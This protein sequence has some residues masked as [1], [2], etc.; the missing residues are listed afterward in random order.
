MLRKTFILTAVLF[1]FFVIITATLSNVVA[2]NTH[3]VRSDEVYSEA[4]ALKYRRESIRSSDGKGWKRDIQGVFEN[5]QLETLAV[6]E[7]IARYKKMLKSDKGFR[8]SSGKLVS[9]RDLNCNDLSDKTFDFH[10]LRCLEVM[11]SDDDLHIAEVRNSSF[12]AADLEGAIFRNVYF[13]SCCFKEANLRNVYAL[14]PAAPDSGVMFNDCD[15][16]G[17][18]IGGAKF[19]SITRKQL[20]STSNFR[21]YKGREYTYGDRKRVNLANCIFM[22]LNAHIVDN[23]QPTEE[24][25]LSGVDFNK[26]NNGNPTPAPLHAIGVKFG[27]FE[28][29]NCNFQ[30]ANLRKSRFYKCNLEG[31]NFTKANLADANFGQCILSKCSFKDAEVKNVRFIDYCLLSSYDGFTAASIDDFIQHPMD[32]I[33]SKSLLYNMYFNPYYS[34]SFSTVDA[35]VEYKR[36]PIPAEK[37]ITA[38]QLKSTASY[39]KKELSSVGFG[40]SDLSGIDF[41]RFNLMGCSFMG[42]LQ[43]ANFTDAVIS[44]CSF[45]GCYSPKC[46]F[47]LKTNLTLDQIKSTWNYKT[48]NMAGIKLPEEI[49]KQL[50]AE[51]QTTK[52]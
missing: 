22:G 5:E 18:E 4:N 40:F 38:E 8:T 34:S 16:T 27:H 45:G 28:M 10:V 7:R 26:F 12:Y 47:T 13:I 23:K 41:S 29:R 35:C 36:T 39:K 31:S 42:N 52:S 48:G 37:C 32:F 14:N 33:E 1:S 46:S 19:S 3:E 25:D 15:F 20:L 50:D 17:A 21:Q 6:E 44:G 24:F 49:Q 51:K 9:A 30:N 2:Q 11:E 43:D